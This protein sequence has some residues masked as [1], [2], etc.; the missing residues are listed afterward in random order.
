M[1]ISQDTLN[2]YHEFYSDI[3]QAE[4]ERQQRQLARIDELAME[5]EAEQAEDRIRAAKWTS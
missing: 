3:L 5:I 4:Q 2:H 1:D